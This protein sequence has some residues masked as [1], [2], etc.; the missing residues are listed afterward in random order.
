MSLTLLQLRRIQRVLVVGG[1]VIGIM[2]LVNV[3]IWP[4]VYSDQK[5]QQPHTKVEKPTPK[6]RPT[7]K[8]KCLNIFKLVHTAASEILKTSNSNIF[9]Y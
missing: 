4:V 7:R 3:I 8:G 6:P 9:Q 1:A 2:V 5:G